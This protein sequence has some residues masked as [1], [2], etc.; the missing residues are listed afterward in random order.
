MAFLGFSFGL[1]LTLIFFA[2]NSSSAASRK[3][4]ENLVISMRYAVFDEIH[5]LYSDATFN[6]FCHMLLRYIPFV[7]RNV[8]RIYM[9]ATSWEI[10]EYICKYEKEK[11]SQNLSNP[12]MAPFMDQFFV[13]IFNLPQS[14]VPFKPISIYHYVISPN[15]SSY[16]LRFFSTPRKKKASEDQGED[17]SKKAAATVKLLSDTIDPNE[18]TIIFIDNKADGNQIYQCLTKE[19]IS[20]AYVDKDGPV[21]ENA[22]ADIINNERFDAKVLIATSA[23]DSGINIVDDEVK[24]LIVFYTDR[25]QF[26]QALG[27]KR[28]KSEETVN[29]WAFV[30]SK[31]ALKWQETAY[32]KSALSVIQLLY[33]GYYDPKNPHN[34]INKIITNIAAPILTA[35]DL[36]SFCRLSKNKHSSDYAY[37]GG[38]QKI[39]AELYKSNPEP[40]TLTYI[41]SDGK[42]YC[43]FYVL[44]VILRKMH[45]LMRFVFPNKD[46]LIKDYRQVVGEWL[47]KPNILEEI[48]R[49]S[50]AAIQ[51]EKAGLEKLLRASLQRELTDK[52]FDP[53]R[54]A[55][56]NAHIN[57]IP[58]SELKKRNS[59]YKRKMGD[60]ALS[61]LLSE[62]GLP[63][64][65]S[66]RRKNSGGKNNS[67]WHAWTI[68][69]L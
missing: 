50:E 30:P 60:K 9:T 28:L 35:E 51:G 54:T 58:N 57:A 45:F 68:S 48:S 62:L 25:T 12:P 36:S 19:G 66:S 7:F 65:I 40:P 49:E 39:T 27:R 33:A 2:P 17:I 23:L 20:A 31:Q 14:D 46:D 47:D 59:E 15:F 52:S 10:F 3:F 37:Y 8:I 63:Y 34:D 44:G 16:N 22:K 29:V 42:I 21:P 32:Y 67:V 64:E 56:I 55:I 61:R 24:N 5:F 4:S 1:N 6:S 53:I 69:R 26:I 11:Y 18:K 13:R 41:N 38:F 43:N